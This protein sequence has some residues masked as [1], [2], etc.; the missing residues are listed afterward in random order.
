MTML[1]Q[2]SAC[3]S[4]S[5]PLEEGDRFCGVC[6]ADLTAAAR[7][8]P[9]AGEVRRPAPEVP[10][11]NGGMPSAT[12]A[13]PTGA[14]PAPPSVPPA[15]APPAPPGFPAAPV[16]P[17]AQAAVPP[18]PQTP[19]VPETPPVPA[20][21]APTAT[22]T[23]PD[24][25]LPPAAELPVQPVHPVHPEPAAQAPPT[26]PAGQP[27]YGQPEPAGQP[28]YGQPH[29]EQPH[30]QPGTPDAP[31]PGPAVT[32]PRTTDPRVMLDDSP[33]SEPP[34]PPLAQPQPAA[35]SSP[36][37]LPDGQAAAAV[38]RCVACGTG[39]IDGDG[40]CEHCGHKQP[41]ERDHM[42]YE[43]RSVA[44]AS[45]RGLRHHR[46]EDFFALFEAATSEGSPA[47]IAVICDGVSSATRPDDASAAAARAASV[48]MRDAVPKGTP[49]QQAMH[50]ALL[51]A[52]DAV[53]ALAAEGPNEPSKNAPA[54][55][56]VSSLTADGILTVGW[57]GDSRAYWVPED[58]TAPSAR[59]TEDDSWAAQMVAAGLM[60]EDEA[61]A[62]ARAHA[63]TGW[64]GAD[65][66]EIEPHTASFK[67]DR[68]GVVVVCTD[69]LWNYAESAE[70][71]AAALPADAR[72]RPMQ[73]AQRLVGYAL[74]G[75]GHDNVTV[76]IV[77]FPVTEAGVG[78]LV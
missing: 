48:S 4:C 51:A 42:E 66:Y 57:I 60:S 18:V 13:A 12:A 5:E 1:D 76:A 16:P 78:G 72:E 70:Q 59:L 75:G 54:C 11:G 62:D 27:P 26:P 53:T 41:R 35:T 71:M 34:P 22:P 19:P 47:T 23:E 55:T 46:N 33:Q 30:P 73:S 25:T 10:A 43:L 15:P 28:S 58:R 2:L 6:G 17:P 74:D 49:P 50:T 29:P 52:A 44:A 24:F 20:T 56:I 21:A 65:A 77:P 69:G 32:D 38:S 39:A 8:L 67:P 14:V 37:T 31:P 3:P 36:P 40:Y 64:L 45:D 7:Q 61:Y 9:G 63:I 68:P